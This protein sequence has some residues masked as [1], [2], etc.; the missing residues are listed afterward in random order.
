MNRK[1]VWFVAYTFYAVLFIIVT[2]VGTTRVEYSIK[3][4]LC[5]SV[6]DIVTIVLCSII[7]VSFHLLQSFLSNRLS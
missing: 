1:L 7:V 5:F 4:E 6:S 2:L 3:N